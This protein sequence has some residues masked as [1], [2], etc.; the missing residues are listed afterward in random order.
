MSIL[1]TLM[2]DVT[3]LGVFNFVT[4]GMEVKEKLSFFGM[5][6]VGGVNF[7]SNLRDIIYE[8]SLPVLYLTI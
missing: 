4:L 8:S 6:E 2:K 3:Q 1:G 5:T 7:G